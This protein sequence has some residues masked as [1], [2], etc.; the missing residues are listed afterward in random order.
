[1]LKA[2]WTTAMPQAANGLVHKIKVDHGVQTVETGPEKT[3]T[4]MMLK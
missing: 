1:M 2:E 3:V 4:P